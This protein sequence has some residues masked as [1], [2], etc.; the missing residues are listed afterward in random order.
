MF[1]LEDTLKNFQWSFWFPG[2]V[3]EDHLIKSPLGLLQALEIIILMTGAWKLFFN[4]ITIPK[5]I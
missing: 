3:F 2:S 4:R 5:T 1:Y